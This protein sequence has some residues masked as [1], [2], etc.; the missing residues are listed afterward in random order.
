MSVL[1]KALNPAKAATSRTTQNV[2]VSAGTVAGLVAF[3]RSMW[4]GVIPWDEANDAEAI[5]GLMVVFV[6]LL[7]RLLAFVRDPSKLKRS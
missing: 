6:P 1:S 2:A 5:G 4:P 3:V 7:S